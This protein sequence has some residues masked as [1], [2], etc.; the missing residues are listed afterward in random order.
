MENLIQERL[1]TTEAYS[2]TTQKL[3]DICS[4]GDDLPDD[5]VVDLVV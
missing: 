1:N 4:I 5:L 2:D 3:K